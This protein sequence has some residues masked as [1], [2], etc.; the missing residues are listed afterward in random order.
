MD[1][2]DHGD[3]ETWLATCDV[4]ATLFSVAGL[5]HAYL[6]SYSCEPIGTV[7]YLLHKPESRAYAKEITG[8]EI[9]PITQKGMGMAVTDGARLNS[10]LERALTYGQA[11]IYFEASKSLRQ[12]DPCV[13]IVSLVLRRLKEGPP[14]ARASITGR[15]LG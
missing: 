7:L 5:D 3:V 9:P 12:Q 4:V 11:Q 2:T 14:P 1:V 8:L 15:S 10:T 13:E 6:S